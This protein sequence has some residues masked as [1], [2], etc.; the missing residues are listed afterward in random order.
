[1]DKGHKLQLLDGDWHC[2][3]CARTGKWL[4]NKCD[5][6]HSHIDH[7][8]VRYPH[9]DA[10]HTCGRFTFHTSKPAQAA[11]I[12]A[13][14]CQPATRFLT[15][16][17][18]HDLELHDRIWRCRWCQ[19]SGAKLKLSCPGNRPAAKPA[20]AFKHPTRAAIRKGKARKIWGRRKPQ[21][22]PAQH[23]KPYPYRG[24][25][26]SIRAAWPLFPPPVCHPIA[27][28]TEE[29][30]VIGSR[31]PHTGTGRG[32]PPERGGGRGGAPATRAAS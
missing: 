8:I 27:S 2:D 28:P 24:V 22:L 21:R 4:V 6:P 3:T 25:V 12:W 32:R 9:A 16:S 1:M 19:F 29:A 20:F 30:D 13:T 15:Y 18:S 14:E 7:T 26:S 5:D 31:A 10:C 17:D 11:K 23:T